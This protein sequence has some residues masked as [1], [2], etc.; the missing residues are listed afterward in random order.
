MI[1]TL[2]ESKSV[3][4]EWWIKCL[5][6][7]DVPWERSSLQ[8]H[9]LE[10]KGWDWE[11]EHPSAQIFLTAQA[12]VDDKLSSMT[13][14]RLNNWFHHPLLSVSWGLKELIPNTLWD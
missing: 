8:G 9:L 1:M 5:A 12:Q 13:L 14:R 2:Q 10:Q 11:Q 3:T 6:Q 7:E 4:T